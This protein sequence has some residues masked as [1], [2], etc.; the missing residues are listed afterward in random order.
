MRPMVRRSR[1]L[2]DIILVAVHR[3][4]DDG[5]LELAARLLRLSEGVMP[6]EPD[7]RRRQHEMGT[8]I[9]AY[10]RLW[11]L[12]HAEAELLPDST[13]LENSAASP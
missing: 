7:P 6:D 10:E 2:H 12:C 13:F 1:R 4:C 5:H 3:A 11:H 9:A 8:L